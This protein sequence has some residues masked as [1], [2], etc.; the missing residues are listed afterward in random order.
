MVSPWTDLGLTLHRFG[1]YLLRK[2]ADIDLEYEI[3]KCLKITL[4]SKVRFTPTILS[5]PPPL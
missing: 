3:I 4:N 1:P 2:P 5:C